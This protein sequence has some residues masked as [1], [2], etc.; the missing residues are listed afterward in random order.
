MT[1]LETRL[2]GAHRDNLTE[3]ETTEAMAQEGCELEWDG[4]WR[5]VRSFY[6]TIGG[7]RTGFYVGWIPEENRFYGL[8]KETGETIEA[9]SQKN[10][11]WV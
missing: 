6:V 11:R 3:A 2:I 9:Y 5:G 7:K 4:A 10:S 1:D 8:L